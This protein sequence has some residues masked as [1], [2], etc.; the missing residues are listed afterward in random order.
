MNLPRFF[1]PY[2]VREKGGNLKILTELSCC[3]SVFALMYIL[4]TPIFI[5]DY[6]AFDMKM[7][8]LRSN[9]LLQQSSNSSGEEFFTDQWINF[10]EF[11]QG[12]ASFYSP[13]AAGMTLKNS[14]KNQIQLP[15]RTGRHYFILCNNRMAVTICSWLD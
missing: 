11:C 14:H 7:S 2:I 5:S 10:E 8:S 12:V 13:Q 3:Y 4:H 1:T 9:F 6:C 15:S